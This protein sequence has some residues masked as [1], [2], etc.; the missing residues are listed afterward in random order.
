MAVELEQV[1]VVPGPAR[2][3]EEPATQPPPPQPPP[4]L[5]RE[6]AAAAARLRARELRL[7]AD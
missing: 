7:G 3:G 5:T 4:D 2:K 6:L 1:E